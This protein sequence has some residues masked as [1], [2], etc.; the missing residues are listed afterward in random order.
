MPLS[1][2]S[3]GRPSSL[4]DLQFAFQQR[5]PN[6]VLRQL[7]NTRILLRTG[8][9][10]RDFSENQNEDAAL[11]EAVLVALKDFGHDLSA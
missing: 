11:I 4:N 2:S 3:A 5:V 7:L 10:L 9:N 8:V 1:T 6:E